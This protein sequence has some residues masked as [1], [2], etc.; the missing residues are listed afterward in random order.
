VGK[1]LT[2]L[3]WE[4]QEKL[5]C[6]LSLSLWTCMELVHVALQIPATAPH[7]SA[8]AEMELLWA[9]DVLELQRKSNT[10]F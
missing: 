9:S 6:M 8:A 1:Q 5:A 4:V 7:G 10:F 3:D 2:G